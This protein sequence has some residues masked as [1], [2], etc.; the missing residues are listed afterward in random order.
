MASVAPGSQV[1]QL[2]PQVG[3]DRNRNLVIGVQVSL[4][5]L[6][7]FAQFV[8][9]PLD[10]RVAQFEASAVRDD[11]RLPPAIYTSPLVSLEAENPKPAVVCVVPTR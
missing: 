8:Q 1:V 10:R 9:N 5:A 11:V 2:Q 3:P 4:A 6:L 7:P